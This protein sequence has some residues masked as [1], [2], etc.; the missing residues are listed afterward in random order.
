M[1]KSFLILG[2][3]L[4]SFSVTAQDIFG[5]WI[6]VDDQTGEEKSIVEIYK[7][8]NG[9]VYGK[10]VEIFDASKRDLPCIVC[11]GDDYNKPVLG[12]EIIKNMVKEGEYYKKGTVIDPQD[13]KVY[14]LRLSLDETD[15]TILL[16]RGYIG[17]F[18]STQYW[19]RAKI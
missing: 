18:Y 2:V 15:S 16:V 10:I 8:D 4:L 19:K 11:K 7:S 3:L 6:T 1:R 13:G 9:K 12:L 5:K 14:K 17:F